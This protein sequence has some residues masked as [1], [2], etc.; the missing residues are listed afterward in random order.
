MRRPVSRY[1]RSVAY[2]KLCLA[3]KRQSEL[4]IPRQGAAP[5]CAECDRTKCPNCRAPVINPTATLCQT[6][7]LVLPPLQP[8]P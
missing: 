7:G 3:N 8:R 1:V 2:C 6:C 4:Y 5:V